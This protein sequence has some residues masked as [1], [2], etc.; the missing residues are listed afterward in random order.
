MRH[1]VAQRA[2]TDNYNPALPMDDVVASFKSAREARRTQDLASV[3]RVRGLRVTAAVFAFAKDARR[4]T[5]TL[6]TFAN[7]H[8]AAVARAN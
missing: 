1:A 5:H 6:S 8:R 7:I 2:Q 4:T 3:H